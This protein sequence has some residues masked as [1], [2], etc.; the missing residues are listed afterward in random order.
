MN[1][2]SSI[3]SIRNNISTIVYVYNPINNNSV[4]TVPNGNFQLPEVGINSAAS[5]SINTANNNTSVIPN[6]NCLWSINPE[7][8]PHVLYL[9]IQK[10][11]SYYNA[12]AASNLGAPI[13]QNLFT[14][15]YHDMENV[16]LSQ[17]ISIT[18]PGIYLVTFSVQ[19]HNVRAFGDSTVT[20][21]LGTN[22]YK[23]NSL[24]NL[25]TWYTF[26]FAA[27][28]TTTTNLLKV[29]YNT[30]GIM[31]TGISIK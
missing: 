18:N 26:T 5:F 6:W 11:T 8:Q 4:V 14:Y 30:R 19:L 15:F 9:E 22:S 31:I 21:S 12:N 7:P 10:G 1:T 27:N 16:T 24:I 25:N 3:S 2:I 29:Y 20:V 28:I 13:T 17:N 23:T